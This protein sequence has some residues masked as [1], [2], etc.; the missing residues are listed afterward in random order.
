[1]CVTVFVRARVSQRRHV[2]SST[3]GDN[4]ALDF[5]KTAEAAVMRSPPE[6]VK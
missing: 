6:E 1:M 3:F 4:I 5:A 2:A